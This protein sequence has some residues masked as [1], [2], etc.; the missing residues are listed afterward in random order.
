MQYQYFHNNTKIM[1]SDLKTSTYGLKSKNITLESYYRGLPKAT[2]PKS[3]FIALVA[4]K[5][6]VTHITVRNWIKYGMRPNNPAHIKIL[7]E[8]TGIPEEELFKR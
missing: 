5:C 1:E 8:I 3:S 2:Y 6:E 4:S 7:S